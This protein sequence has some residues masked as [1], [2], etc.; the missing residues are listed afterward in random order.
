M[1]T[2]CCIRVSQVGGGR[3]AMTC[4]VAKR[5]DEARRVASQDGT[6]KEAVRE[7]ALRAHM[8]VRWESVEALSVSL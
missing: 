5:R 8:K 1:V 4:C 2:T 7:G 3:Q 6:Q